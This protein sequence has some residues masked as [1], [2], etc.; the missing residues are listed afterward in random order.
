MQ[1]V[2]RNEA[3]NFPTFGCAVRTGTVTRCEVAEVAVLTNEGR[4]HP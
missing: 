2:F 1:R 4:I 3:L